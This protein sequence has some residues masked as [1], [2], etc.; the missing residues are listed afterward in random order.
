MMF[1]D[2]PIHIVSGVVAAIV[3]LGILWSRGTFSSRKQHRNRNKFS[4]DGSVQ[5][6]LMEIN[7][8][9]LDNQSSNKFHYD[10]RITSAVLE[11][12]RR[13]DSLYE[14]RDYNGPYGVS[15]RSSKSDDVPVV[16]NIKDVDPE[17]SVEVDSSQ[18]KPTQSVAVKKESVVAT[19]DV[20]VKA[21]DVKPGERVAVK[22]AQ[23]KPMQKVLKKSMVSGE[24]NLVDKEDVDLNETIIA[25]SSQLNPEESVVVKASQV[26]PNKTVVAKG[27]SLSAGKKV[28]VKAEKIKPN[29]SVIVPASATSPGAA[30]KPVAA[31]PAGA[32]QIGVPASSDG[33]EIEVAE[34]ISLGTVEN[35]LGGDARFGKVYSMN[36]YPTR[37]AYATVS[38]RQK[39]SEFPVR[40][41]VHTS[42]I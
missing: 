8:E 35:R 24:S 15:T 41:T 10:N 30:V 7:S 1:A 17:S 5:R 6:G 40:S 39:L 21:K 22:P 26:K 16:A 19:E 38:T 27:N 28:T 3:L 13:L 31:P 9:Q 32:P 25:D 34:P 2:L 11:D 18:I 33:I 23:V 12:G 29:E 20:V 4:S 37:K 36:K 14:E 42:M